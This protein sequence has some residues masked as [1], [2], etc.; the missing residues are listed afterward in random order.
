[1]KETGS[2]MLQRMG[3]KLAT[4]FNQNPDN[5]YYY[6]LQINALM[7]KQLT[8]KFDLEARSLPFLCC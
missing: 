1:M 2:L 6:W 7:N 5:R 8:C 3:F 4:L